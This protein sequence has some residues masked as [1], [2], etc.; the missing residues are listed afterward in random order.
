MTAKAADAPDLTVAVVGAGAMGRGIAQ[1]AATGGLRVLLHDA[2]PGAAA[3][4]RDFIAKMLDRAVEKGRMT[5]G[6][7]AAASGRVTPVDD[8]AALAPADVVIEAIVEDMDAKA[9]LF[10][11]LEAVVGADCI[12]ASNTSSLSITRIAAACADASRVAGLHFF[13]PVPLMPLVEV[14][15]GIRTAPRALEVLT[16]LGA[17]MGRTPV[18]VADAPGFLVNQVGR[19]YTLEATH[20]VAEGVTDFAGVDRIMREAAGFRMGPFELLDLTGLDV[21]HPATVEIYEQCFHEPRF[22]PATPMAQR[23]QAGLLGRKTGTGHYAY[24]D[25][26]QVIPDEAPAPRFEG[27]RVWIDPTLPAAAAELSRIAAAAGATRDDAS[28]PEADSVVLITPLGEDATA[29]AVAHGLDAAR[30]VAVDPLFG[31]AGRRS[32]MGTPVTRPDV[33]RAAHAL[34]AADGTPVSVLRDSPGFVAQRILACIVNIAAQVATRGIAAPDD[35]DRAVTLGLNYPK[36]P[37]AWADALGPSRILAI[38]DGLCRSTG[39]PRYRPD[40]WLR[41]RAQLGVSMLV[42]DTRPD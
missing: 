13:N 27:G 25:G 42:E 22:R 37:L 6:D 39:D 12:L 40:P 10:A 41:R 5:A 33:L 29:C 2:R 35:I 23:M 32:M 11:E 17:R 19:G 36:G 38:L 16:A 14:I 21:T 31:F 4:A 15:A 28:M 20:L 1:V 18:R 8:L 7:A 3:E 9:R 24:P 26:K 34:L 30:V